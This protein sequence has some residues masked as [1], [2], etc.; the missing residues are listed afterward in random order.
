MKEYKN[1]YERQ[2][3]FEDLII[4]MGNIKD[5]NGKAI[6][7]FAPHLLELTNIYIQAEESAQ[8]NT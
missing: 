4:R 3:A 5:V 7:V 1:Y 2:V 8:G 6:A